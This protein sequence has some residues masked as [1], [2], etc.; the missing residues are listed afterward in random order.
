MAKHPGAH[1][2]GPTFQSGLGEA[3]FE[4][5]SVP[6]AATKSHVC[7]NAASGNGSSQS[8]VIAKFESLLSTEKF[9]CYSTT[10]RLQNR[11]RPLSFEKIVSTDHLIYFW[12]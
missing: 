1:K 7:R 12:R 2:V 8:K 10:S 3:G 4:A 6:D 5:Y 9:R 11:L